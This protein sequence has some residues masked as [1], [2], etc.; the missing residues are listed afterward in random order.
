MFDVVEP[1]YAI[2][3]VFSVRGTMCGFE[4]DGGGVNGNLLAPT[5][6]LKFNILSS[7]CF[8]CFNQKNRLTVLLGFRIEN[9]AKITT[10]RVAVFVGN[11][12]IT[13]VDGL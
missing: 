10:T 7:Y 12:S 2:S 4:G 1:L 9:A 3:N 5:P 6:K 11:L 13:V 8:I